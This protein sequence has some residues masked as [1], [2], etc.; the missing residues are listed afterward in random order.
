[1]PIP[2]LLLV[3]A[4][5]LPVAATAQTA[6]PAPAVGQG[7]QRLGAFG[8]WTAATYQEGGQKVCYA[9]TRA[10]KSEG[11]GARQNVMLTVTHRPQGRDQ[12]AATLGYAFPRDPARGQAEVAGSVGANELSFYGA[13][14]NAFAQNGPA[15]VAAF[16]NGR[17][18]VLKGPG[19]Q[20][21]GG[22]TTDTF[23]LG[24]FGGAYE[25]ISRDC[26]A[27]R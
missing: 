2:K 20:G 4:A 22:R 11:G 14:N 21:R 10:A 25:A 3:L 18:L 9:F 7:P 6:R 13:G 5:L 1:M 15:A 19:P 24:G 26:P 17:D 27:R 8:N 23:S 16:R 12:V